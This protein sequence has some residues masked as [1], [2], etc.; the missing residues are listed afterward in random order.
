[1]SALAADVDRDSPAAA[2]RPM[3]E[4][5]LDAVHAIEIRAYEFPWTLGIFRDCLR[6]DYPSWVLYRKDRILG[7]FLMSLAAGEAHILNVCVAP[8]QQ[9][10][11]Y[12]RRLLHALLQ[13]ARGRGAQ[14][15]FLE[16]R[17][18]NPGAIALYHA[19]G[20]N[21]IGRRPRYYPARDGR[22]DA[23]VMAMELFAD[24]G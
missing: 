7:Y 1:M 15:V 5:D 2:L 4:E 13:V 24:E 19:E 21:E 3:R 23:L 8:E 16:V 22:E 18:S 14:R 6:A 11:G 20:F 17:P 12:G 10:H 9:G